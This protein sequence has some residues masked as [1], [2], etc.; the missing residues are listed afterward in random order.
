MSVEA[1][2][3]TEDSA[4]ARRRGAW[5]T[6]KAALGLLRE[7]GWILSLVGIVVLSIVFVFLGRWQFHRHEVRSARN[8]LIKANYDATP[9]PLEQLIPAAALKASAALPHDLQ[10]R[11][12]TVTGE[13]QADR[14]VLI[15]NRPHD[16]IGQAGSLSAGGSN[17][18]NGYEV[19]VPLRT[20]DG[21]V[22][23]VD[24]GWI[25]AGA[26]NASR[27]DS[28]PAAPTGEVTVVARLRPSEEASN[29]S[30]PQ[31]QAARINIPALVRQTGVDTTRVAG[32]FGALVSEDPSAADTPEAAER[33]QESIG[34]NLSY[35]VQWDG[36]AL[37]AYIL[38]GV[39]AVREV[40]RRDE[41]E[42]EDEEEDGPPA[43][44]GATYR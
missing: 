21:A 9:V 2:Q 20:T 14:T 1:P 27:P 37:V 3:E 23:F 25:P 40:R 22:L 38:F 30:A 31:G 10:Y 15:R 24:R 29:R 5:D 35:S 28:V 44:T 34:I 19:V 39:A 17:S 4:P 11:P 32:A 42:T 12:V 26:A 8:H 36:F 43:L 6:T 33:P 16:Q 7:R 41:E 13:Y 18:Q